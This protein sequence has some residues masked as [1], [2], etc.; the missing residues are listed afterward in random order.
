MLPIL[1]TILII[2]SLAIGQTIYTR[3]HYQPPTQYSVVSAQ[4]ITT[5]TPVPT[6]PPIPASKIL[7]SNY[8]VFQ[9]F[10]NCG[11]AALSLALSYYGVNK[12]QQELGQSLRPYQNAAGIND[13]K[14]VTLAEL[15]EKSKEYDL[16]PYHRPNGSIETLKQFI[17]QDMPVI[18][19]TW[20]KPNEDIGHYRVVRGY[21]DIQKILI[22]DDSFQGKNLEYT[23]DDFNTL[24]SK[25]NF[26]YLVLVPADKQHIA[27]VILGDEVDAKVAWQH[28]IETSHK[29]LEQ[30]PNDLTA[31]FDLSVAYFNAGEHARSVE[32]YEKVSDKLPFRTLWYQIEPIAAYYELGNYKQVFEI[33]D[34]I[35]NNQNRAYAEAYLLRGKSYLKQGDKN[36][37]RAEF[38]KA[39][40]YNQ[41]LH[42]AKDA[43]ASIP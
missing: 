1:L 42:A 25:F 34:K 39:V 37:A 41:N 4:S 7:Q 40:L 31:Q 43:L 19:R 35:L 11:P 27:E 36:A 14:S 13:D 6:L 32:A 3:S 23:Y 22:Q 26:E 21:D 30:N 20:L 29:E 2:V 10:N 24:W 9:T 15:A 8:H 17:A 18:T 12:S 38:E 5:P 33:T 16:I 28:A